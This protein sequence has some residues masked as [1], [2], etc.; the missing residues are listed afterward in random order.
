MHEGKAMESDL[1]IVEAKLEDSDL[2]AQ[3]V[4]DLLMELFVEQSH[5]FP[6]EKMKKAASDLLKPGLGVW[7]FLAVDGSEVVGMINLNECS[8]IYAGGKFGEITEMYV[9]PAYRSKGIGK[10]LIEK[11]MAFAK[12]RSWSVI[13]VGAPDVPRCQKTV[14]FYLKEGF[15]EVGPRLEVYV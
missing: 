9:R 11:A 2:V 3:L 13:E 4:Y 5:L 6:I 15:H 14:A 7:S 8:A 10:K 1:K 12:N